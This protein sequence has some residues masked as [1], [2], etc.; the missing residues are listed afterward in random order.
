MNKNKILGLI[1]EIAIQEMARIPTLFQLKTTDKSELDELIPAELKKSGIVNNIIDFYL[2]NNNTPTSTVAVAKSMGYAAQQP[3]NTQ[4]QRLISAG[5]LMGSGLAFPKKEK[6]PSSGLGQ[7]RTVADPTNRSINDN[8]GYII[9]KLKKGEEP[10]N[11]YK[12]WF[13][14]SFGEEKY[15]Q[16]V[17][18]IGELQ[19]TNLK[20]EYARVK[21]EIKDLL[22][23]LGLQFK[24]RGRKSGEPGQ[25]EDL[26]NFQQGDEGE[27][28][29]L[30]ENPVRQPIRPATRPLPGVKEPP[31]KEPGKRPN[32]RPLTPPD[33]ETMPNPKNEN[34]SILNK[35]VNRYRNLK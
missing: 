15:S 31:L 17:S 9:S 1:K 32:R 7:G 14:K 18:L 4:F 26:G 10:N 30:G 6:P 28:L 34:K 35:I 21:N 20:D 2:N 13:N 29:P 19:N 22:M 11:L 16:L 24:K 8:I 3:V 25:P 5:V 27:E 12:E 33:P 23:S